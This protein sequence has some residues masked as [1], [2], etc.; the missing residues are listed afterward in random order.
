MGS[1]SIRIYTLAREL[2]LSSKEVL[3]LSHRLHIEATT[4]SSSVSQAEADRIMAAVQT[5]GA[6]PAPTP[7]PQK[8]QHLRPRLI[9][10]TQPITSIVKLAG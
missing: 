9:C 5:N 7:P 10:R 6:A 2:Q 8:L 3:A 1:D 4:P